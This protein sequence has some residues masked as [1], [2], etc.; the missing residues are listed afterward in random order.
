MI[1]TV[2]INSIE[3]VGP[4]G[5]A[6][7]LINMAKSEFW[8]DKS[9]IVLENMLNMLKIDDSITIYKNIINNIS[10]LKN[11]DYILRAGELALEKMQLVIEQEISTR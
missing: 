2:F 1:E 10:D 3:K 11:R 7:A 6:Y 5:L 4:T 9:I 8:K